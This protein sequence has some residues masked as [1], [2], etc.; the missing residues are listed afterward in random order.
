MVYCN[1]L[2]FGLLLFFQ[3]RS[4]DGSREHTK[5]AVC[6]ENGK[7]KPSVE[8]VTETRQPCSTVEPPRGKREPSNPKRAPGRNE[9]TGGKNPASP[10]PPAGP[11]TK[12]AVCV[13]A[14]VLEEEENCNPRLS[15]EPDSLG[16]QGG[17]PL[18]LTVR[19]NGGGREWVGCPVFFAP[20]IESNGLPLSPLAQ[21]Q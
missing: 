12:R 3:K 9:N 13:K 1:S 20:R 7:D 6:K 15:R 19:R 8:E 11:S 16:A 21:L 10:G 14:N 5:K 4:K 2:T 17:V 18:G